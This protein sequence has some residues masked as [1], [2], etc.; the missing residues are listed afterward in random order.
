MRTLVR[1]SPFVDVSHSIHSREGKVKNFL[2]D[3][4][5]PTHTTG[6]KG[7]VSVVSRAIGI[8]IDLVKGELFPCVPGFFFVRIAEGDNCFYFQGRG[9][10]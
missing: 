1:P 2:V 4:R 7:L 9:D 8:R 6:Q 3:F 10:I 5:P